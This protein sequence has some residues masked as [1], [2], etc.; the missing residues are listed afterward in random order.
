M[1]RHPRLQITAAFRDRV[2]NDPRGI[3]RLANLA[4]YPAY[5]HLTRVLNRPRVSGTALVQARLRVLA[6]VLGFTGDIWHQ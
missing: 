4:A 1:P 3:V 2:K 5:T 6:A